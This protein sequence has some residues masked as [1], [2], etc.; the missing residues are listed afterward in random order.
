MV[1]MHEALQSI[2]KY[3][4]PNK[5]THSDDSK[6]NGIQYKGVFGAFLACGILS[7]LT[8]WYSRIECIKSDIL[9]ADKKFLE[10]FCYANPTFVIKSPFR[11]SS[12]GNQHASPFNKVVHLH[13]YQW[14]TIV[15]F[16]QAAGFQI[17]RLIWKRLEGGRV[18]RMVDQVRGLDFATRAQVHEG[19][20]KLA[21]Y[22]LSKERREADRNYFLYFANSQILYLINTTCQIAF[23]HLFLDRQF[24]QYLPDWLTGE[25]Q[26]LFPQNVKCTFALHAPTGALQRGEVLCTLPMNVLFGRIYL[27]VWILLAVSL[28]AAIYQNLWMCLT[29]MFSKL[30]E[31][32]DSK[33]EQSNS[34][35]LSDWL[36]RRFLRK[37]LDRKVF[38]EFENLIMVP[39]HAVHPHAVPT[40]AEQV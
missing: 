1:A 26:S 4:N 37:S 14:V 20:Q 22:Y 28:G 25:T 30:D 32:A 31:A 39:T 16:L 11:E 5:S 21:D 38:H 40:H 24:L 6:I 18:R 35:V 33:V 27:F 3:F 19:A 2:V 15:L 10:E 8:S 29:V 13:Y 23:T 7:G 17:P 34:S 36:L 9:T 12:I